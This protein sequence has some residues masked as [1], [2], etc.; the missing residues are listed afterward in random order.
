MIALGSRL[1]KVADVIAEQLGVDK[2]KVTREAK[3]QR[4]SV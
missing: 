4:D 1:L 2:E 3:D